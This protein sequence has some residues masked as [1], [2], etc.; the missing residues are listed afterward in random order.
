MKK[1][2]LISISFFGV[3][4]LFAQTPQ[5]ELERSQIKKAEG[6]LYYPESENNLRDSRAIIFYDD[7]SVPGNWTM[8]N[9]S[10]PSYDWEILNAMPGNLISQSFGPNV[11]STSGGN[12][13][14]VNSDA[15]GV[16]AT[17]NCN[18]T[19]TTPIDCSTNMDIVLRF[20]NYHRKFQDIHTVS[21]SNDGVNFNP[22]IVNTNYGSSSNYATSPNIEVCAINISSTA[23]MQSAVWIRFNFN[24]SYDWFW[25][26]DDI[27]VAD[28]D[29]Y[30]IYGRRFGYCDLVPEPVFGA[31]I[32]HTIVPVDQTRPIRILGELKSGGSISTLS[33]IQN[34]IE[35]SSSVTIDSD[36]SSAA[37]LDLTIWRNDSTITNSM[38][39]IDNYTIHCKGKSDSSGIAVTGYHIDLNHIVT[40]SSNSLTSVF[41]R[42]NN[43]F[44]Q[45]G[46]WNGNGYAYTMMNEFVPANDMMVYGV[47]VALTSDTD[48]GAVICAQLLEYDT[49]AFPFNV[50]YIADNCL[51]GIDYTVSA[52]DT[53]G[54]NQIKWVELNFATPQQL[55]AGI[56]YFAGINYYGG[57]EN[58][59]IMYGGK[60]IRSEPTVWI[61]DPTATTG[62]PW[63]YMT[64]IP[65]IRFKTSPTTIDIVE[66]N[67]IEH[68]NLFP[69]PANS[70]TK[71][72]FSL[73]QS[74]DVSIE[75][76]DITGKIILNEN[77]GFLVSGEHSKEIKTQKFPTG[78]YFCKL[79]VGNTSQVIKLQVLN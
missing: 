53:S 30:E 2:L 75:I 26:I 54:N 48:P 70:E 31:R 61:Y 63:F 19:N 69:N 73:M 59:V 71:L 52:S 57:I 18:M 12:F 16:S 15:Q 27:S 37:P 42:D 8:T 47:S 50:I 55:T 72:S 13:A 45:Q 77:L 20:E 7:F 6:K 3:N 5:Q 44:T 32:E 21:V 23:S 14:I 40:D 56:A 11:N 35:N 29:P 9:T 39:S 10:T 28:T 62:G 65:M 24:G 22:Q 41:A 1:Y 67:I 25:A 17:Q 33:Y 58:A 49:T 46:L 36:S 51:D 68:I 43:T 4:L 64:D 76:L 60:T 79:Q 78:I 74:M 66:N 38:I 34:S